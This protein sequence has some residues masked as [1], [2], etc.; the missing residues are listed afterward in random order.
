MALE[1]ERKFL[2]IADHWQQAIE[3][4]QP[5]MQGYLAQGPY[6]NVRIR[7]CDLTAFLTIKGPTTGIGRAEFEY[8]IPTT[9]AEEMLRT[10][11]EGAI[12]EKT[13]YRVRHGQDCWEVDVFAGDNAGLILAELELQT[14]DQVIQIPDWIGAEVS[15]DPRY[16]NAHLARH[17]YRQWAH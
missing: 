2:V 12:I 15:H 3:T 16:F 11:A 4:T 17:P 5:M 1:L 14:P 6:A 10:L 9:D 13:R 8:P 7:L